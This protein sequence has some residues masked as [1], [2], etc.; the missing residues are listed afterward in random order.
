MEIWRFNVK[1]W[2]LFHSEDLDPNPNRDRGPCLQGSKPILL[3]YLGGGNSNICIFSP[4][5]REMIQFDSYFSKGLKP[6]TSYLLKNSDW[7]IPQ[8]KVVPKFIFSSFPKKDPSEN[9]LPLTDLS[10][11]KSL[12]CEKTFRN[13]GDEGSVYGGTTEILCPDNCCIRF[14]P[15]KCWTDFTWRATQFFWGGSKFCWIFSRR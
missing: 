9:G 5:P 15:Q 12:L 14:E 7:I 11:C 13:W 6:P 1:N 4:N 8:K 10:G 2:K 3:P